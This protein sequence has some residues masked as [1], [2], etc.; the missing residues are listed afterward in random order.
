MRKGSKRRK[1]K[2]KRRERGGERARGEEKKQALMEWSS[3][4]GGERELR[5]PG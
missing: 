4:G 5:G 1:E 3:K 2:E